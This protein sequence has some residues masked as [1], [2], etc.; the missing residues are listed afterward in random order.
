MFVSPYSPAQK[1]MATNI[2]VP[3]LV[4]WAAIAFRRVIQEAGNN[5][6]FQ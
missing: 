4:L 3:L 6:H 1:C 2:I 5:Q